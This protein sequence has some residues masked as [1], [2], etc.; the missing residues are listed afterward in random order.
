M[1]RG[2]KLIKHQGARAAHL[3]EG[4]AASPMRRGLKHGQRGAGA[5][6]RSDGRR[7]LPDEK[8]I[9]TQLRAGTGYNY[10]QSGGAASP[11]KRGL[12]R[13]GQTNGIVVLQEEGGAASP[14]RRGLKLQRGSLHVDD[15]IWR[16]RAIMTH[17]P[18]GGFP[19]AGRPEELG[20]R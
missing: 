14:M 16:R 13:D 3:L 1:R 15:V 7:R 2:L 6:R 20:A 18:G 10:A 5:L 17:K 19:P 8:G 9:E 11:M 12:K 4:G